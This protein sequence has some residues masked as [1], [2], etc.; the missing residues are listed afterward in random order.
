MLQAEGLWRERNSLMNHWSTPVCKDG[1]LYGMFSFKDYGDGPLQCVDLSTG[2]VRWSEAGFGA[3]NCILVGSD[4]VAL[5]DAGQVVLVEAVPQEYR[6]LARAQVL[7]GKC[8][9]TPV[10]SEGQLYVR[11]TSQAARLDLTVE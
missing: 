4:L 8:W 1:F 7:E 9:S 2:E 11:S 3:G 6:E 5:G 10:F